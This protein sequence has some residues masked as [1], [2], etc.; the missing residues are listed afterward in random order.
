MLKKLWLM[1]ES[2]SRDNYAVLNETL[3]TIR[4]NSIFASDD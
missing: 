4:K 3:C 1:N 2:R